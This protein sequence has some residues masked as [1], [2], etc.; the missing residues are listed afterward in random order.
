MRGRDSIDRANSSFYV[1]RQSRFTLE[2][3][4]EVSSAR[5]RAWGSESTSFER[6]VGSKYRIQNEYL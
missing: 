2:F 4:S 5:F 1:C 3:L 6:T